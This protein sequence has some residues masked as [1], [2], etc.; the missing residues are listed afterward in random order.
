MHGRSG[1]R[2]G[3]SCIESYYCIAIIHITKCEPNC[4]ESLTIARIQLYRPDNDFM[5]S[6]PT[7]MY[8]VCI[9]LMVYMHVVDMI[10]V[11]IR[12]NIY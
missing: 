9:K 1:V 7:S 12:A 3:K 2:A 4:H 11:I 10:S 5:K 6:I 8:K